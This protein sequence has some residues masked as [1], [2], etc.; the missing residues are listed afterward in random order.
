MSKE[1]VEAI[2]YEQWNELYAG[3]TDF[4]IRIALTDLNQSVKQI[5]VNFL[6]E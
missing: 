5:T 6:K 4:Y 1:T 2:T 3:A